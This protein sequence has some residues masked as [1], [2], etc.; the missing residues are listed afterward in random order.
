MIEHQYQTTVL[1]GQ[2]IK[3]EVSGTCS[4]IDQAIVAKKNYLL[5]A[6]L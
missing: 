5:C 4:V 6:L 3:F 2:F 1:G